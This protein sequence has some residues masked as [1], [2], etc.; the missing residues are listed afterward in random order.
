M[1]NILLVFK[2]L[3]MVLVIFVLC[4]SVLLLVLIS[5]SPIKTFQ[6][7]RVMSG[8]MEPEIKTGSVIF[9]EQV[10]PKDLKKGDIIT[11]SVNKSVSPVTH[12]IVKIS[13]DGKITTKGD[14]N[15]TNDVDA[16]SLSSVKGGEIFTLP[17][18]GYISE[19]TK[20]PL[21]FIFFIILPALLIIINEIF[22]IRK[23]VKDEIKN[24]VNEAKMPIILILFLTSTVISLIIIRPTG[25]FFSNGLALS[26]NIFSTGY[27][28]ASGQKITICHATSS[29]NN[30]YNEISVNLSSLGDGHGSSGI[31]S[32]D[33]IP[34]TQD[35]N[36]P[37][38]HNWT[39]L[40]QAIW[41]NKCEIPDKIP[42]PTLTLIESSDNKYLTFTIEGVSDYKN[43]SYTL[44]YDTS[45]VPQGVI[46]SDS[47]K[48]STYSS[49]QIIL[50]TCSTGGLCV[51]NS[52]IHNI[53]LKV[54]LNGKGGL[55][56]VL[57][58]SL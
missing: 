33:I 30:P 29:K 38:G 4:I 40:G 7:F 13:K 37:N 41:N 12:R 19:W 16:V 10:N 45:S 15:S 52:G 24:K 8:S 32:D 25:A 50:G 17:Y 39:A 54:T 46:G 22:N 44:T 21:G 49:P 31:N 35:S 55:T 23:I 47:V 51:Y 2:K 11:F 42:T 9:V 14:A 20:T 1:K 34:P 18:L 56:K 6:V 57:T 26:G 48:G 58:G 5:F 43:L 36:Y 53:V 27:W 28:E 3:L